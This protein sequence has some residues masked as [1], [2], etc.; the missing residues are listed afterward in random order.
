M[1]TWGAPFLRAAWRRD[2]DGPAAFV[3]GYHRVGV[4]E[5]DPWGLAVSS[6]HLAAQ[7]E[8]LARHAVPVHA[9]DLA[10]ALT[11]QRLAPRTVMVTFDDG[12]ADLVEAVLPVLKRHG[13][14]ATMFITAG[15]IDSDREFWWD[16]LEAIALSTRALPGRLDL[17]VGRRKIAWRGSTDPS[18]AET[19]AATTEPSSEPASDRWRAWR[20]PRTD[21]QRLFIALWR[22]LHTA[23][24]AE[25][26]V[27]LDSLHAWA[28]TDRVARPSHRTLRSDDVRLLAESGLVELGAH[29]VA[30]PSLAALPVDEQEH[31]IE[32]GRRRLQDVSGVPVTSFAYPHGGPRDLTRQ[33]VA[34][35]RSAGFD[36]AYTTI[37]D[38][39]TPRSPRWRL[40]RVMAED[41]DA[42]G[43]A[44][45]LRS[46]GMIVQS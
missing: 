25:R 23:R 2:S 1:R 44:R 10:E 4:L 7:L 21:R 31:E 34:L 22:A 26:E 43:L 41:T 18:F 33:T 35:V 36:S 8:F 37:P 20:A 15:A 3:V 12:Y 42:D 5:H 29:T 30:H 38:R 24:P 11:R 45:R 17:E 40:P 13:I 14:R 28:R 46:V 6:A 32:E 19:R 39:V 9:R 16:Q 27:A